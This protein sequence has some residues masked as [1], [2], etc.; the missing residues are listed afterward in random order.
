MVGRLRLQVPGCIAPRSPGRAVVALGNRAA[1]W[2]PGTFRA[3]ELGEGGARLERGRDAGGVTEGSPEPGRADVRR[4]GDAQG[5]PGPERDVE[6]RGDPR[7]RRE[8]FLAG[9]GEKGIK[10]GGGVRVGGTDE[11]KHSEIPPATGGDAGR[12]REWVRERDG[13]R[14]VRRHRDT[15]KRRAEEWKRQ[16]LALKEKDTEE[17]RHGGPERLTARWRAAERQ[18]QRQI[19]AGRG[20]VSGRQKQEC[21]R[22]LARGQGTR[23][24]SETDIT[25]IGASRPR[26]GH[27]MATGTDR[28]RAKKTE[29]QR[30]GTGTES[31]R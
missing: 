8:R 2:E 6:G 10:M 16:R 21:R 7:A 12:A 22:H 14:E 19:E 3:R 28:H 26:E 31:Q 27:R 18:P 4:D 30:Q 29:K 15:G 24:H 11:L 17:R 13:H 9:E 25:E 1:L 23:I 5:F 20:R